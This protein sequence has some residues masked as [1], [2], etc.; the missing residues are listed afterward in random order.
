MKWLMG[1]LRSLFC[2]HEWMPYGGPSIYNLKVCK[3]C[4]RER[5]NGYI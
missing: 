4:G 5:R 3:K 2:R 1:K